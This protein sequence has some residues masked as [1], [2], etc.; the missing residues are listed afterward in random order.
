MQAA[1]SSPT[2]T[3]LV[4]LIGSFFIALITAG[5]WVWRHKSNLDTDDHDRI[6]ELDDEERSN[7]KAE[8]TQLYLDIEERL[9]DTSAPDKTPHSEQVAN[10]IEDEVDPEEVDPLVDELD[11]I[12]KS[13][14]YYENHEQYLTSCYRHLFQAA[15]G[16]VLLGIAMIGIWISEYQLFG[17]SSVLVYGVIGVFIIGEVK[18]GYDCFS[19]AD[20]QKSKFESEWRE[21]KTPD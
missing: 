21:Y 17:A 2:V 16:D 20:E 19:E 3:P 4:S 13:R 8:V 14:S 9:E 1:A 15:A 11:K 12:G 5:L 6:R 18:S 10:L 7:F